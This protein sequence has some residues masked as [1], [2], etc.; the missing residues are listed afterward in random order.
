M[1]YW[2]QDLRAITQVALSYS[3]VHYCI[4]RYNYANPVVLIQIA[5][6]QER[7]LLQWFSSKTESECTIIKLQ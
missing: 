3:C 7:K 6:G 5:T 1:L 2:V 4:I